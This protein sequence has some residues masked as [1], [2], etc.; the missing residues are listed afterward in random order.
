MSGPVEHRGPGPGVYVGHRAPDGG[1]TVTRPDGSPLPLA[2]SLAIRN[3][4][5]TGWEWGYHGSGPAQL[6]L[7]LLLDLTGDPDTAAA[8]YQDFKAAHVA[9]W[10]GRTWA[11]DPADLR[12]WLAAA[13]R[14]ARA[15][16]Q[17]SNRNKPVEVDARETPII[18]PR[19]SP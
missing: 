9:I 19:P 8:R 13:D 1:T 3:H 16:E 11:L 15:L 4:S 14:H 17:W 10:R 5:P 12:G 7:A 18:E 6:A 2:P